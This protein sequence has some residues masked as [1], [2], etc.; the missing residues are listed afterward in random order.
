MYNNYIMGTVMSGL[1]TYQIIKTGFGIFFIILLL[2]GAIYMVYYTHKKNY[3][4]ASRCN[5]TSNTD[6]NQ[7]TQSLTYIIQGETYNKIVPAQITTQN[8]ISTKRYAHSDGSCK[9]YYAG[10]NPNDYSVNANPSTVSKIIAGVLFFF[11]ILS[12]GWFIFLRANRDVAGVVGG[13]DAASTVA[14]MF[15]RS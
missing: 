11:A 5:I 4:V 15:R 12:I 2:C 6:D 3:Q 8:N 10:A 13:I 1:A 7:V 9:L 14:G